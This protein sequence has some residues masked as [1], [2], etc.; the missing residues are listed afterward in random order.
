[1]LGFKSMKNKELVVD[2]DFKDL[3][4]RSSLIVNLLGKETDRGCA[5]VAGAALD[6]VLGGLLTVYLL[7]DKEIVNALFSNPNAPISTFSARIWLCR[8][9]G[10]ISKELCHDIHAIRHIR[11]QAAHFENRKGHGHDFA[12]KRQDVADRCRGLQSLPPTLASL[13]DPR[14]IFQLFVGMA[15]GCL[16]EHAINW[17]LV[18]DNLGETAARQCMLEAVPT[19]DLKGHLQRVLDA[20]QAPE[21]GPETNKS[22]S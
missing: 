19:I 22:E 11:N 18:A 2:S 15:A 4:R 8:G 12:F 9:I 14:F 7:K 1:V 6:E 5:L 16:G 20:R 10:L 13:Y 21:A 17:K 3:M